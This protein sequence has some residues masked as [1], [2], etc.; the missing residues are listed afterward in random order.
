MGFFENNG[1]CD[2][3]ETGCQQCAVDNTGAFPTFCLV[4]ALKA[5]NNGDGSCGCGD[6]TVLVEAAGTLY[7]RPCSSACATCQGTYDNCQSCNAPFIHN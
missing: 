5:V 4:C 1:N 2:A 6:G 7:C 3:C